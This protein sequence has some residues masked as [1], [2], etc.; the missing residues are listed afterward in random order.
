MV[1]DWQGR[2]G[3]EGKGEGYK[4]MIRNWKRGNSKVGGMGGS[5]EDK[6]ELIA[7]LMSRRRGGQGKAEG[8][9]KGKYSR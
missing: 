6:V 8:E 2:G 5:G 7:C 1:R 3:F 9:E 4:V